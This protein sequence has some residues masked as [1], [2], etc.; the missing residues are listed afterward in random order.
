MGS[1][2][3]PLVQPNN[4]FDPGSKMTFSLLMLSVLMVTAIGGVRIHGGEE[5]EEGEFPHIISIR[6]IANAFQHM[7]AGS[8][9]SP[10]WVLTSAF[11][12]TEVGTYSIDAVGGDHDLLMPSLHEQIRGVDQI[13]MHPNYTHS[14]ASIGGLATP[15]TNDIALVRLKSPMEMTDFV[16]VIPLTREEVL[17]GDCITAGW[18]T[19]SLGS[20][21]PGRL[22]QKSAAPLIDRADCM[23]KL[24]TCQNQGCPPL[25]EDAICA[26]GEIASGPCFGY[27]W[28]DAGGPLSCGGVLTGVVSWGVGC[29]ELAM[30]WV[31]TEVA[32]HL[33][34]IAQV[35]GI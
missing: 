29:E 2:F 20:L 22:L 23:D 16:Q 25:A 4:M 10:E 8:L 31:N 34:W 32:K 33:D 30:P 28:A 3:P 5:A 11:C 19:H 7:C 15:E 26:G 12:V 27:L 24:S 18:G 21:I 6:R 17:E 35:A 13:I 9:I 1:H 14:D